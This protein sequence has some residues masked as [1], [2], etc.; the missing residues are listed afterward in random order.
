MRTV[1]SKNDVYFSQLTE[2]YEVGKQSQMP[3]FPSRLVCSLLLIIMLHSLHV[4]PL[5]LLENLIRFGRRVPIYH[6]KL[7]DLAQTNDDRNHTF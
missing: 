6:Q 7:E 4:V 3:A 2:H 1:Q 5:H